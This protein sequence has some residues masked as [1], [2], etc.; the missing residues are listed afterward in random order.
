MTN[1]MD[2]IPPY[3]PDFNPIEEVFA[4][5]K[6][7]LRKEMNPLTMNKDLAKLLSRFSKKN[8]NLAGYYRHA[9]G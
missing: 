1:I 6:A 5:M 8:H 3:S 9:F 2:V 4:E 7:F